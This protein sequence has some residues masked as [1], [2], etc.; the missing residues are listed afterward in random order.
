MRPHAI[1]SLAALLALS[2]CAPDFAGP[3]K[4]TALRVLAVKAEPPEIGAGGDNARSAADWP[5][6][7]TTLDALIGHPD[8]AAD[9]RTDRAVVLHLACTPA[10]G[11]AL[12]TICTQ[13]SAL[14][15]PSALRLDLSTAC[16]ATGAKHL[17]VVGG[18]TIAGLQSCNRSGCHSLAVRSDANDPGSLVDFG[19]SDYQLPTDAATDSFLGELPEG[20]RQRLLGTDAVV[21]SFAIEVGPEDSLSPAAPVPA[22][23]GALLPQIV[24]WFG[25]HWPVRPHVASLK[26]IHVRGPEMPPQFPPNANPQ[27]SGIGVPAGDGTADANPL[28]TSLAAGKQLDLLPVLPP[29]GFDGLRQDYQRFDTDGNLVD[30]RKEEWAYSWFTTRGDLD[31]SHTT[32]WDERNAFTPKAGAAMLWLVV[33][34]LRGGEVWTAAPVQAQ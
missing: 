28:P 4:V 11:S 6:A 18:I 3:E 16:P 29:P 14:S 32:S 1:A 12:G 33:R 34:D 31:Q 20:N 17:G 27:L 10:P 30:T 2:A 8:F 13:T 26:W 19:P 15:E 7:F 21:L 22:T 25:L 23:C 9:D 5:A 24:D